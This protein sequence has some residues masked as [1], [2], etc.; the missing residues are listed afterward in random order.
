LAELRGTTQTQEKQRSFAH[1]REIPRQET[2]R[3][4]QSMQERKDAGERRIQNNGQEI[5]VDAL[6]A[7]R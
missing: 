5:Q 4:I 1:F 2:S 3:G 7:A 6:P